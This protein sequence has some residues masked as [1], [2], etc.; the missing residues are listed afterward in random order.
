M[1]SLSRWLVALA[2]LLLLVVFVAPLWHFDFEAPQYPEGLEMSIYVN[3]LGGAFHLINS[4]NHYVGMKPIEAEDFRE[5]VIFPWAVVAL[6]ALGLIVALVGRLGLLAAWVAIFTIAAL[7]AFADFYHWLYA[8][9]HNLDPR[10][11]IT[12]DPFTPPVLGSK[13]VMNFVVAARPALGGLAVIAAF[14]LGWFALL[15]DLFRRRR[16]RRRTQQPAPP[17]H[18]AP[19]PTTA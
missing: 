11:A 1:S 3:R 12:M 2:A 15:F 7:A 6:T 9:G 4:L 14:A 18:P 10:A 19:T 5:L 17:R 13:T 8:Y 16:A